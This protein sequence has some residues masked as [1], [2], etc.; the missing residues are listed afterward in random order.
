MLLL[1]VCV[2]VCVCVSQD[3]T[4]KEQSTSTSE[5]RCK[6]K[7][8]TY[9]LYQ[10]F[11]P[12]FVTSVFCGITC[13]VLLGELTGCMRFLVPTPNKSEPKSERDTIACVMFVPRAAT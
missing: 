1:V 5:M 2:C 4:A 3:V 7:V 10:K 6:C 12:E 13:L 11:S 9:V 8:D